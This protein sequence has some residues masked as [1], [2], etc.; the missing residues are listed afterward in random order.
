MELIVQPA[1][2]VKPVL[3]GINRAAKTLDLII[4]RL[5]M[6]AIEKAIMKSDLGLTPVNDGKTIRLT[7]PTPT[8]ERRKQLAKT[9][10]KLAEEGPMSALDANRRTI[11]VIGLIAV[12]T[13]VYSIFQSY[14]ERHKPQEASGPM[15]EPRA[16]IIQS[17]VYRCAF[18]LMWVGFF[19][20]ILHE[21]LVAVRPKDERP[22]IF[23]LVIGVPSLALAI[24]AFGQEFLGTLR[25]GAGQENPSGSAFALDSGC[26]FRSAPRGGR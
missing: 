14:R 11:G 8:E 2:G 3:D 5:D 19:I 4:F 22:A 23:P 13:I 12:A 26:C 7:M 21:T 6:K 9:V 1:D 15:A 16:T 18:A 24:L 17:P 20:Y 10:G 25:G